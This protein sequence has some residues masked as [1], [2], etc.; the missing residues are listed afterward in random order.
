MNTN[1]GTNTVNT[2]SETPYLAQT[3]QTTYLLAQMTTNQW[4]SANFLTSCM[5]SVAITGVTVA[6]TG[7][8]AFKSTLASLSAALLYLCLI[9]IYFL[10]MTTAQGNGDSGHTMISWITAIYSTES[11]KE[12]SYLKV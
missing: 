1:L 10:L 6:G 3:W 2:L 8:T 12:Y 5:Q 11:T 9:T 4:S 7:M